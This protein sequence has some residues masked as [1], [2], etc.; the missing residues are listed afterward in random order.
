LQRIKVVCAECGKIEYVVPSRAKRY[1]CCS[2]KCLGAYNSKKYSKQIELTC[3]ICGQT[4]FCKKS[5]INH[6]KTC[7]RLG[8][9]KEW[10]KRISSG[11]NNSN[12]KTVENILKESGITQQLH[13]SQRKIYKH[14]VKNVLGLKSI[15]DIPK[16]Y[17]I[18]HKDANHCNNIPENLILLPKTAHRLIHT[19]F[20]NILINALHTNKISREQFFNLCTEE[21]RN[22]YKEIIDLNIKHQV[23]VKQGELLESPEEDNQHPSIYRNIIEGSTTNERVLTDNAEDC[24][25][26]TS[27]LP[28]RNVS[29]DIV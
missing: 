13:D 6:H 14:V 8:C 27:A 16:N 18:H 24:N 15:S 19:I 20:G 1:C 4:Y 22:F 26:D 2:T 7:G 29:D 12:Y 23:V 11:S 25:F 28:N 17:V 5:S 9:I 10:R 21:Q 3:P